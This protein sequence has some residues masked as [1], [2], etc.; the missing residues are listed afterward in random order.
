MA[1]CQIREPKE[2]EIDFILAIGGGSVIDC[3]KFIAAGAKTDRDFWQ[4]FFIN[5][6]NCYDAL[7][8]GTVLTISGTGSEMDNGG[9]ITNWE[10]NIKTSYGN[11]LLYPKFSILDPTYTYTV[12]NNQ[13]IFTSVDILSHIFEVYFSAPDS[14][15]LS[16]DIAE[17]IIKNVIENLNV[18]LAN[19]YDY[20]ARAN[21]MWASSMAINGLL[22]L[23]KEQEWM[24]H[25]IEHALS[26]FYDIPHG[27]GLAVV[28]PNYMRYVYKN[29]PTKF[30]RY[31]KNIW[32]VDPSGKS[33]EEIAL[34]GIERTKAYFKTI[35]A[36]TTLHDVNIPATAIDEIAKH[37]NVF[38]TSYAKS[39]THQD[40]KN[41]L[42]LCLS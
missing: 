14:S 17:A 18:A 24:S 41:I 23:G 6:E 40:I 30:A 8:L 25:Q 7:P 19:P 13:L 22:E 29:A 37:T 38:P 36:P 3:S 26:A 1:L 20:T 15:N 5:W 28:H 11:E 4:A 34:E 31:A 12:P 16:D 27:A 42:E 9:V 35:G 10:E 33:D 2:N 39:M 21:L 32:R